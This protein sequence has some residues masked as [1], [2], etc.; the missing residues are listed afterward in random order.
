M[1]SLSPWVR[2]PKQAVQWA[3][4][5]APAQLLMLKAKVKG[6]R[7]STNTYKYCKWS[8]SIP[9]L[10]NV[11][12]W[13]QSLSDHSVGYE[14]Q[15]ITNQNRDPVWN[16]NFLDLFWYQLL[17][18]S[19]NLKIL[20]GILEAFALFHDSHKMSCQF[21]GDAARFPSIF[22]V[23]PFCSLASL[24]LKV[25][26][27]T[28]TGHT[29]HTGPCPD[30]SGSFM[31]KYRKIHHPHLIGSCIPFWWILWWKGLHLHCG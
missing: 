3:H 24:T 7:L 26:L 28:S 18:P 12:L 11:K 6:A 8:A 20:S 31:E 25:K 14:L 17:I 19:Q 2:R 15:S 27:T 16:T 30:L 1:L 9:H 13:I 21:F 22:D 4:H 23:F 10:P 5:K 29:G